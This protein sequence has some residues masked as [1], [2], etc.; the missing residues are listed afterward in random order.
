M[1]NSINNNNEKKLKLKLW[2]ILVRFLRLFPKKFP[3]G[4]YS[5]GG[6]A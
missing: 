4:G 3:Y 1:I 2:T 6:Y 5:L